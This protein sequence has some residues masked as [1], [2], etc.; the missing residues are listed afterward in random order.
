MRSS[1]AVIIPVISATI[2]TR[3]QTGPRIYAIVAR[4][5]ISLD[6]F[7]GFRL[8]ETKLVIYGKELPMAIWNCE[9]CGYEKEGRC[10]PKKCPECDEQTVFVKQEQ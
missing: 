4:L 5:L 1:R 6:R 3:R 7:A 10:K 2:A 9:D 8:N